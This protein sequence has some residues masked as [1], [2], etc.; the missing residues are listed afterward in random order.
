MHKNVYLIGA[1][2]SVG[3]AVAIAYYQFYRKNREN[4]KVLGA[5][6]VQKDAYYKC[7]SDCERSDPGKQLTPSHGNL[8]CQE[9]C[10]STLTDITRRSGPSY[11]SDLPVA[12]INVSTI[13]DEAYNV[14]GDG[15]QNRFCRDKYA[16]GREIDEKCRQD[17]EYSTYATGE[18]MDLCTKSKVG[19][20]SRG[21]TWK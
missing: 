13:V 12:K 16:T 19:N 14:C 7:S 15:E 6:G 4:F 18:C 8:M 11:P 10:D 20:Y 21:W 17:C 2:V 1:G 9:Y 3:I 5:L